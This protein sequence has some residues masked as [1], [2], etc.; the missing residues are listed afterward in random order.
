MTGVLTGFAIIALVVFVGYVAGRREIG[1]AG[2]QR[3]LQLVAFYIASPALLFEVLSRSDLS[4]VLSAGAATA[5]I[6]ALVTAA[7]YVAVSALM[8]RRPAGDT[9]IG[10]LASSYVNANNIGLPVAIYV[11]GDARY[12]APVLLLQLVVITPV[13]LTILDFSTAGTTSVARTVIEPLRNPMIVASAAGLTVAATGVTLPEPVFAPFELV[14]GAAIPLM[15]LAFGISLSGE[16][17]LQPGPHRMRVLLACTLKSAVMPIIAFVL[18][19]HIFGI[20]GHS[21]FAAVALAALP[22]AQNI[23]TLAT[24]YQVEVVMARDTSLATTVAAIP[25]LVVISLLL[26]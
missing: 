11:L 6:A 14:G 8:W 3:S 25:T 4:V 10:A 21:L 17:P 19:H 16:R 2:T 23:F 12:V 5:G 20:D 26:H 9:V 22:T 13:A 7:L 18:A 1:G 24:R 15:L